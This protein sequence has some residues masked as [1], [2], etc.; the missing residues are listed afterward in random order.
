MPVTINPDILRGWGV[1]EYDWHLGA[2]IQREVLPRTSVEVGYYRRW[3][4]NFLV[5]DNRAVGPADFDQFTVNAPQH[6]SLPGGGGYPLTFQD[7]RRLTQDNYLT[8]ETD[9]APR[10]TQYWHGVDV[11]FTARPIGTLALQGGTSTG[12]G[13][14]EHCAL[15]QALPELFATGGIRQPL[16]SC[17]TSEPFLTQFRGVASYNIPQID[18]TLSAGVQSK[19]GTLGIPAGLVESGSNGLSMA[20]NV[21]VTN[22]VI[23]QSLGRVPTGQ[24]SLTGT[25]TVNMLLPGEMYGDRINQVDLRFAKSFGVGRTKALVGL[26]L[27]NLFNANPTLSYNQ[28]FAANW[29]RPTSILLSRFL[30]FNA[31]VNF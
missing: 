21:A 13:V 23:A 7:A 9:Y 12:R 26:D 14:R 27:Y 2:S 4:G 1:R 31:T 15:V 8:F 24:T 30:R 10:R 11:N 17:A 19:P 6:Q 20:A 16:E 3:F 28:A 22:A 29:P 5:T 25:T 18:V